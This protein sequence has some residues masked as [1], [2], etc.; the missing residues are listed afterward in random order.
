MPGPMMATSSRAHINALIDRE[1]TMIKSA[2]GRSSVTDG[3]VLRAARKAM[4]I[5]STTPAAVPMV[6]M[7]R[8]SQSGLSSSG[9]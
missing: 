8:V 3:V 2:I 6:A 5:A 1:V 7:L 9:R 4:G